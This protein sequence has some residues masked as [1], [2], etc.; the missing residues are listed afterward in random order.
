MI[1]I[2][3]NVLEAFTTSQ[4]ER[5]ISDSNTS[6]TI[7]VKTHRS[8][9]RERKRERLTLAPFIVKAIDLYTKRGL[10]LGEG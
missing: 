7:T 6:H 1:K 5:V 4:P 9:Q 2:T 3:I 8:V 10:G